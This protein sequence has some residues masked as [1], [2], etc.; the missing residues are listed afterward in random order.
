[1][2]NL[3]KQVWEEIVCWLTEILFDFTKVKSV[4]QTYIAV[5]VCLLYNSNFNDDN[6]IHTY[7]NMH[8][9]LLGTSNWSI[10]SC[11]VKKKKIDY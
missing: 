8:V 1:M 3:F 11:S 4:K 2:S 10:Y 5:G 6:T 9:L 7:K